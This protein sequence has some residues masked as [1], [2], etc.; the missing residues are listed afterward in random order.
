MAK[1]DQK[2]IDLICIDNTDYLQKQQIIYFN[3]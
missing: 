2:R 3:I 1:M